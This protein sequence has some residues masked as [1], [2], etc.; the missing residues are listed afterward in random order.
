MSRISP[1]MLH[2]RAF[3]ACKAAGL[4]YGPAYGP[5]NKAIVGSVQLDHAACYGGWDLVQIVNEG[6]AI[7]QLNGWCNRLKASEMM[8]FLEGMIL[9]AGAKES[10][11]LTACTAISEKATGDSLTTDE[12]RLVDAAVRC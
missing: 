8:A 4:M 10:A 2:H 1:K 11:A 7:K 9:A 6:G 3:I 5:D 12:L